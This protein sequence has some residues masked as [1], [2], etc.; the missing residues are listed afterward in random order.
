MT[1][2]LTPEDIN[3]LLSEA[4]ELI[5]SIETEAVQDM[6]A[7]RRIQFEKDAQELKRLR[8]EA[9][10]RIEKEGRPDSAKFGDGMHEAFE[11]IVKAMKD[12]GDYL[13]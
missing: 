6:Q 9:Q 11:D 4:D 10:T 7:D 5:K 12:L 13:T 2:E 8:L 3:K 1:T